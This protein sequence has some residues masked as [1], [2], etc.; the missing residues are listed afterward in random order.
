MKENFFTRAL[1]LSVIL[2]AILLTAF[3]LIW[4]TQRVQG[5]GF[6][7]VT[8]NVASSTSQIIPAR[9]ARVLFATS[10]PCTTRIITSRASPLMLTFSNYNNASPTGVFGHYQAASTTVAYE[11]GVYGCG[12][13]KVYADVADTITVTETQ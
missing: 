12:L 8:V 9:T 6:I 5:N 3:L 10:T 13:V 7:G 4:N 1:G 2:G 11:A